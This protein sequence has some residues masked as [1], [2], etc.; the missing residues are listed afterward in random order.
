VFFAA[1]ECSYH[2]DAS[3]SCF[4]DPG[5]S[6]EPSKSADGA[7]IRCPSDHSVMSRSKIE[8]SPADAPIYLDRCASCLGV[9]FDQGEWAGLASRHLLEHLDEFWTV[10]WRNRQ[11][12]QHEHLQY[13]Q[14]LREEFGE[15]LYT[16]LVEIAALL[17]DHPRRSQALAIIREES[18]LST[19]G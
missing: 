9:W 1:R 11:R 12:K 10:E 13:E 17:R 3:S 7:A 18:A 14:R 8:T 16:K 19:A 5:F 4:A 2:G 6:V 15:A